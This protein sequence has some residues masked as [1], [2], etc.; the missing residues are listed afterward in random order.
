MNAF[1][2]FTLG[3]ALVASSAG[4]A[5]A[6]SPTSLTISMKALNGS[7]EDGTAIL[8]QRKDGVHIVVTLSNDAQRHAACSR[9]TF[10]PTI[11]T[12]NL[13]LG[14]GNIQDGKG[15]SVVTKMTLADMINGKYVINVHASTS[16]MGTYVSCGEIAAS[17]SGT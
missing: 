2:L 17:S 9:R 13:V 10:M 15:T 8:T 5:V 3:A 16:K 12:C 4:I 11:A 6:A 7:H 14:L 1:R